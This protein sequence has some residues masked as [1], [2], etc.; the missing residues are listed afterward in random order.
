MHSGHR[1]RRERS[2]SSS[3]PTIRRVWICD[4]ALAAVETALEAEPSP[5]S[6]WSTPDT[7]PQGESTTY[8]CLIKPYL[9]EDLIAAAE[10]LLEP[11]SSP[12]DKP[13]SGEMVDAPRPD[14]HPC[15][16]VAMPRPGCRRQRDRC[17]VITSFLGQDGFR[18][19]KGRRTAR[20]PW[21][22]H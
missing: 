1:S 9:A 17:R 11:V 20:R 8:R 10:A 19:D 7:V 12:S 14:W 18:A 2:I 16:R 13:Q 15:E 22:K 3:S 4:A 21:P 5:A 6:F